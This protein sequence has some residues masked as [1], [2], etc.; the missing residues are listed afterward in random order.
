LAQNFPR[1]NRIISG[2]SLGVLVVEASLNSGALIT[3]DFA[4]EQGRE[5]FAL[6]GKIDAFNSLG[7]NALI[8]QGAKLVTDLDDIL[9]EFREEFLFP[10]VK[11]DK[12]GF[13]LSKDKERLLALITKEPIHFDELIES[14][15][16]SLPKLTQLLFALKI[17][18]AIKEL[19]GKY[20][21]SE[22]KVKA[23]KFGSN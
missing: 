20:Y 19:A 1:R 22:D 15:G 5:V 17:D 14:S 6:P 8:Q 21:I 12:K 10:Q 23:K 4:L 18:K 16:F 3:A 9:E 7:T 11:E 2:L 13:T